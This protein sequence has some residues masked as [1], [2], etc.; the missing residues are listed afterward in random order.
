MAKLAIIGGTGLNKMSDF[1]VIRREVVHTPFGE[2]S[3]ALTHG[4]L[5]DNEVIFLPRHGP[6]HNIPPHK[7]NY[8]ANLW[9]LKH[10]GVDRVIGVAAVGGISAEMSPGR[11]IIPDQIIDYTYGRDHTLF[12]YDLNQVT[13]IDFTQPY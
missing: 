12:E 6:A 7:V 1:H 8:R 10:I 3:A 5:T 9:A 4:V 13:H 2:P 11:V